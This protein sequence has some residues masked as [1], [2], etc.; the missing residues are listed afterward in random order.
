[1]ICPKRTYDLQ[2]HQD[3]EEIVR[4]AEEVER[5]DFAVAGVIV[6]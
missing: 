2:M 6:S 1:V 5:E 3:L 4:R